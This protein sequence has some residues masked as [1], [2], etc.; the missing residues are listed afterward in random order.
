MS[1]VITDIVNFQKSVLNLQDDVNNFL[2]DNIS[3]YK[4]KSLQNLSQEEQFKTLEKMMTIKLIESQNLNV[5][6]ENVNLQGIVDNITTCIN[7][8]IN[9]IT[10]KQYVQ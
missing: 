7:Y 6:K 10:I 4:N 9:L 5:G 2:N 8:C 1:S 3:N